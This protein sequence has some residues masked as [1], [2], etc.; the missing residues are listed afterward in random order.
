MEKI[1]FAQHFGTM[2]IWYC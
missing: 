1:L 2:T